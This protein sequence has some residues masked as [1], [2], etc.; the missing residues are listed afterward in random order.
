MADRTPETKPPRGMAAGKVLIVILVCLVT[1]TVLYSSELRR[2]AETHDLGIRRELSLALIRPIAA[3]SDLI[4]L[5]EVTEALGQATGGG[6]DPLG[7]IDIPPPEDLPTVS[8]SPT[9]PPKHPNRDRPIREPTAEDRLRTVVIGDSLAAGIG[10]FAE[11]VFKPFFVDVVRQ[12]VISSGLSRP[13][14]YNWPAHLHNIMDVYHPDLVIVMVGENDNQSLMTVDQHLDTP[15]GT[16]SWGPAYE[17]RV[18]QLAKIATRNGAHVLW[19]GLPIVRDAGR[20]TLIQRQNDIYES[21]ARRLA[22]VAFVNTWDLFAA[23]DGGYT[24]YYRD[25]GKVDL[26]RTD[27]GVHFTSDG[28][29]ILMNAVARAATEDFD[30]DPKTYG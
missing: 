27:D 29:T 9:K 14:F 7:G 26:V 18:Q 4:K 5:S 6:E 28:Y 30:L 10:S 16:I 20:G 11:R 24:A 3:L 17:E 23:G 13:D 21:V 25:D 19:V 12:G 15:I 2:A 22:N 8:V 1:W